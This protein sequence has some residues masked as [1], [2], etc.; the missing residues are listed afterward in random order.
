MNIRMNIRE[1]ADEAHVPLILEPLGG[2]RVIYANRKIRIEGIPPEMS[3]EEF[4]QFVHF[5]KK[6]EEALDVADSGKGG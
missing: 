2:P 1:F 5:M 3:R 6:A 4:W